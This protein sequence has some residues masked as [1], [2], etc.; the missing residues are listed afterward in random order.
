MRRSA[1]EADGAQR[2]GVGRAENL[3]ELGGDA[4]TA[5]RAYGSQVAD[6]IRD[7]E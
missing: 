7:A 5:V 1:Y 3:R 6:L 2:I 4:R